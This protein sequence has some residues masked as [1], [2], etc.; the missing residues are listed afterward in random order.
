V[1]DVKTAGSRKHLSIDGS[2]LEVLKAWK[3]T[4]QCSRS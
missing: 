1:D 3:Q 2:L 4:T